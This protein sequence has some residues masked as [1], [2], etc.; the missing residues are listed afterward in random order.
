MNML[1]TILSE[2]TFD[3]YYKDDIS[4]QDYLKAFGIKIETLSYISFLDKLIAFID[5]I[6]ELE[7]CSILILCNIKSY[8][9]N[10]Q[11]IEIYKFAQYKQI[12]LLL[13]E[14]KISDICLKNERKMV[15]DEDFH[16]YLVEK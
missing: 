2:F 3:I 10:E 11:L 8:F 12:K 16:D 1:D 14:P 4:I 5:I 13:I 7:L 9:K 15:I 6:S